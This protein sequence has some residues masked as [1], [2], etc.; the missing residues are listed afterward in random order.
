MT[1]LS[2]VTPCSA[3]PAPPAVPAPRVLH[4]EARSP[5][6][7]DGASPLGVV[8]FGAP[9]P[10]LVSGPRLPVHPAA[11]SARTAA[12]TSPREAP[13]IERCMRGCMRHSFPARREG[14]LPEH[15][16]S[17]P[18]SLTTAETRTAQTS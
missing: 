2:L 12:M 13:R 17:A 10:T 1:T 6:L 16:L 18:R 7:A 15:R 14:I 9:T 11:T 8:A 5:K 4:G 3:G